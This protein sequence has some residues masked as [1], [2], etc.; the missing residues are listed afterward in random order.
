MDLGIILVAA[1]AST[2]M[3]FAK[4]YAD[5]RG[6]T[7]LE[8]AV[9]FA[10][11]AG[12]AEVI[13]VVSAD[14]LTSADLP[15]VRL[16]AG[17]SRRRDSVAAGLAVS[18]CDWIAIHDAAR[19]LAPSELYARGLA[20]AQKTGA[21]IPVLPLKDTI[22][23]VSDSRVVETP[24]RA[25]HVV[26]QTPQVFRRDLLDRA[27]ASTDE[28]VTD[29]AALVERLGVAVATFEGD[30]RAFK[31]TTPLDFALARTLLSQ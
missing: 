10:H 12:A 17:G 26:V 2:R 4:L 14:R 30:E 31:I 27:L 11:C 5:L 8:H 16:V 20:A 19:A 1:G 3:G 9:A 29:E 18:T 28:D 6:Q 22:K 15:G 23:R 25:E 7:V 24:P 13:V 21:A